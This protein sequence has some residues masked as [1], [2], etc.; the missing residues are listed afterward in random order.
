MFEVFPSA[1]IGI[2]SFQSRP[3]TARAARWS[4]VPAPWTPDSPVCGL[5]QSDGNPTLDISARPRVGLTPLFARRLDKLFRVS[6]ASTPS[7][8]S[9]DATKGNKFERCWWHASSY[10][11]FFDLSASCRHFS[12]V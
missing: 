5:H 6:P 8:P 2:V 11:F 1:P 4:S 3:L 7:I 10:I 12:S 9:T